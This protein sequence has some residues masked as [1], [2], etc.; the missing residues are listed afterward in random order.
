MQVN[1]AEGVEGRVGRVPL[2][3]VFWLKGVGANWGLILVAGDAVF[4]IAQAAHMGK[5]AQWE[6][7]ANGV[8]KRPHI[9]LPLQG[10][11]LVCGWGVL[12]GW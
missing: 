3:G 7:A 12:F 4:A 9:G 8:L 10:S 1:V 11:N 2:T 5:F 6:L